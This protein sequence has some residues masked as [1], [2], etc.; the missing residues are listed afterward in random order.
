[1]PAIG[2]ELV[3]PVGGVERKARV[4]QIGQDGNAMVDVL[5]DNG[6]SI[7]STFTKLLAPGK[8]APG[9]IVAS[10]EAIASADRGVAQTAAKKAE[11]GALADKSGAVSRAQSVIDGF[12][13]TPPLGGAAKEQYD[14]ALKTLSANP[15][16]T[17]AVSR[18]QDP[19]EAPVVE[20]P[21]AEVPEVGVEYGVRPKEV[22]AFDL[23]LDAQKNAINKEVALGEKIAAQ[24]FGAA[25]E[26]SRINQKR[27]QDFLDQQ[28][29][30][31][32]KLGEMEVKRQAA[33][34]A[35]KDFK[36]QDYWADKSTGQKIGAGLS[37]LL[38]SIG[39]SLSGTNDNAA[40]E[41]ING[42]IQRDIKLQ[43]MNYEKLKDGVGEADSAYSRLYKQ[44]GD[45]EQTINQLYIMGLESTKS[46]LQEKIQ[47]FGGEQAKVN[48]MKALA[49]IQVKVDQLNA[50]MSAKMAA[51]VAKSMAASKDMQQNLI[52]ALGIYATT[53]EGASKMNEL[54]GS[55]RAAQDGI[56]QLLSFS[57]QAGKS[58]SPEMR[59]KA[60]TTASLVQAALRVPILGPGVVNEREFKL[61]ERIVANPTDVFSL[62]NVNQVRLKQLS[63]RLEAG[64]VQQ[65][66]AYEVPNQQVGAATLQAGYI[67]VKSPDGQEGRIRS[68]K[69]QAALARGYEIIK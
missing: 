69:V 19:I 3:I 23:G 28:A 41:V 47:Q 17:A 18:I 52:P 68:D 29:V 14:F 34:D 6:G 65:A 25:Q 26:V 24:Q 66:K 15:A 31:E 20:T 48:G 11:A 56:G 9:P 61:L 43:Q 60:E 12:G 30:S 44:L 2:D 10:P 27:E 57:A 13:G 50:D 59:A 32:K 38:G 37:I 67:N 53:K 49:D 46:K 21:V 51:Q 8:L 33:T 42:A 54:A 16:P 58:I 62:D 63:E 1:M 45:K 22:G 36:F 35:V 64:L 5:D 7:M 39:G 4:K 55:T 40:L